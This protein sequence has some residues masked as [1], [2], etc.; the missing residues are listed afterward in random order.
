MIEVVHARGSEPA[1]DIIDTLREMVVAFRQVEDPD[2]V[3]PVI[4]DG[5]RTASTPEEVAAFMEELR[6]DLLL[7]NKYQSDTCYVDGVDGTC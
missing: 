1:A 2:A 3:V 6:R 4:R 5:E 7:W